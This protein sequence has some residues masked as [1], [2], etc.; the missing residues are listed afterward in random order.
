MCLQ[1]CVFGERVLAAGR[2]P[3]P[4][5]SS[6]TLRK[7]LSEARAVTTEQYP[8]FLASLPALGWQFDGSHLGGDGLVVQAA[9][10]YWNT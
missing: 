9:S 4:P 2:V 1:A 10:G 7:F 3:S 6:S 8:A 5:L